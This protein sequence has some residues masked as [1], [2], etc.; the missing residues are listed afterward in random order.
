MAALTSAILQG[1][2]RAQLVTQGRGA[3]FVLL[4]SCGC[5]KSWTLE[6]LLVTSWA[7]CSLLMGALPTCVPAPALILTVGLTQASN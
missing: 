6:A 1:T 4:P 5:S 7:S 2:L 3:G